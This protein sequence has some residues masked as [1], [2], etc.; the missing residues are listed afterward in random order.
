M[1]KTYQIVSSS[2]PAKRRV[3]LA[4]NG[5]FG[6][7][8]LP[9]LEHSIADAERTTHEVEV[10]LAEV[11]LLDRAIARYFA[12]RASHAVRLVN[13]PNYLRQWIPQVSNES[14]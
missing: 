4:L 10:D 9:E 5:R 13:C 3:T 8:A 7:D 6:E 11:T 1:T 12:T 14:E 2:D